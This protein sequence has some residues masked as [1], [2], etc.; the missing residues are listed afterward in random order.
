MAVDD[1]QQKARVGRLAASWSHLTVGPDDDLAELHEF[2]R[3]L[4]LQRR[5]F[6]DKPW[7]RQHYDVTESKRQQAIRL[8]AVAITWREAGEQMRA[9]IASLPPCGCPA[10]PG[11]CPHCG[12]LAGDGHNARCHRAAVGSGQ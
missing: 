11:E 12:R 9:A 1:W 3:R 2:A 5:W 8:G 10:A 4:G 6:Q 7:P